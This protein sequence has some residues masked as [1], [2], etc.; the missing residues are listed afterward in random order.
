VSPGPTGDALQFEVIDARRRRAE[1]SVRAAFDLGVR[2]VSDLI[3]TPNVFSVVVASLA[4]SS[5]SGDV[6]AGGTRPIRT[7]VA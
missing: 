1:R 4:C 2:P 5:V 6:S 3:R 7:D